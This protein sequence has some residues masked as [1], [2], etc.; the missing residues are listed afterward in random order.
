ME[1]NKIIDELYR[2]IAEYQKEK[3][4]KYN[5]RLEALYSQVDILEAIKNGSADEIIKTWHRCL[6]EDKPGRG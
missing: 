1:I 3:S 5:F 4:D 2:I 6:T